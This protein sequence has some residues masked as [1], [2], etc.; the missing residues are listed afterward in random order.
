MGSE[1]NCQRRAAIFAGIRGDFWARPP[2][3]THANADIGGPRPAAAREVDSGRARGVAA[4][5]E[6]SP[7]GAF[8]VF[9]RS[10]F[11]SSG[12]SGYNEDAL[13]SSKLILS[14]RQKSWA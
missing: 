3:P 14:I 7:Y 9:T 11:R 5:V 4:V 10:G 12:K 8:I 6:V 1:G 2:D 13:K